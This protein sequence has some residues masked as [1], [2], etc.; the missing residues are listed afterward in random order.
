[1]SFVTEAYAENT[2]SATPANGAPQSDLVGFLTPFLLI[3]VVFYFLILR[4]QQKK[5]KTH[6]AMIAGVRRG[7]KVVTSGG[8]VGKVAKVNVESGTVQV[9]IS[10][11]V[12]VEVIASTIA[13]VVSASQPVNDNAK[14]A[15]EA[16]QKKKEKK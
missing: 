9:E 13:S 6:Q 11:N 7:D 12:E 15:A 2:A 16:K 3:F 8:I 5:F 14:A 1:M 4:P 10:E